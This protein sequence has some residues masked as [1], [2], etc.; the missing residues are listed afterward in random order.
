M[1]QCKVC[2]ET[3]QSDQFFCS[4]CGTRFEGNVDSNS[5]KSVNN[6]YI[7]ETLYLNQKVLCC[8][9]PRSFPTPLTITNK[10]V[11]FKAGFAGLS[12]KI[13]PMQEITRVEF[14]SQKVLVGKKQDGVKIFER[15]KGTD[16]L[17]TYTFLIG[18][19]KADEA[20]FIIN[21]INQYIN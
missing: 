18:K 15:I 12:E 20:N 5:N 9:N 4:K 16:N 14:T 6:N 7:E 2:G 3:L 19:D 17:T 21:T 8:G 1:K 13:I 11:K 10:V